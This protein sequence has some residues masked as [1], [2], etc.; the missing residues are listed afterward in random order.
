MLTLCKH[1][2]LSSKKWDKSCVKT[3]QNTGMID[4]LGT[5]VEVNKQAILSCFQKR[6]MGQAG[7]I[8]VRQVTT[9]FDEWKPVTV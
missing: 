2:L 6:N 3:K 4:W 7:N 1:K 8:D 9:T 5:H